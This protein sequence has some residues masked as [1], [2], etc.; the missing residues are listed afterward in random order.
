VLSVNSALSAW[1]AFSARGAGL[2]FGDPAR[3]PRLVAGAIVVAAG[4]AIA[5]SASRARA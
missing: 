3:R 5:L 2:V 4:A 1:S